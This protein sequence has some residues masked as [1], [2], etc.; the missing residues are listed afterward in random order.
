M[1][2]CRLGELEEYSRDTF[3]VK[4]VYDGVQS[5]ARLLHLLPG[6][7]VPAHPHPGQEL[8]LLPQRG[9][10]TLFRAGQ[11][12]LLLTPGAFYYMG[13]E[14][15]LGLRNT[16]NEPFQTLVVLVRIAGTK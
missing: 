5:Q 8:I 9:E 6:Q 15:V 1:I 14:P 3:L 7:E 10:A 11:G 2:E 13:T 4:K 16:G 12:D